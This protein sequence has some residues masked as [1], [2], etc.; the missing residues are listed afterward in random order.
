[1]SLEK[2][3][4]KHVIT[5]THCEK[6]AASLNVLAAD[7]MALYL[8]TKNYHWHLYGPQFRDCHLL[9]DEQAA[10]ILDMLDVVAERVRKLG[11]PTLTSIAHVAKLKKLADDDELGLDVKEMLKRLHHDNYALCVELRAS[12]KLSQDCQD[13]ATSSLI[14]VFLDETERRIW[15]LSALLG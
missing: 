1:M 7:V 3:K 13:F 10:Q 12:H 6:M 14:E 4:V 2:L 8:K 5:P 15:F 11:Q 9:F